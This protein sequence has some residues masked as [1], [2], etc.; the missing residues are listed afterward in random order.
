MKNRPE[1][2]FFPILGHAIF[3]GDLMF[4]LFLVCPEFLI[5]LLSLFR[6]ILGDFQ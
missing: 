4:L 3:F 6:K 5:S 1:H 2:F